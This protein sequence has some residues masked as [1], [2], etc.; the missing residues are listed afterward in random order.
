MEEKFTKKYFNQLK[1]RKSIKGH[2]ESD[3]ANS[4]IRKILSQLSK[5]FPAVDEDYFKNCLEFF[6]YKCPYTDEKANEYYDK[7]KHLIK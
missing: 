5:K 7:I 4:S 6:D 3:V 2:S 1:N